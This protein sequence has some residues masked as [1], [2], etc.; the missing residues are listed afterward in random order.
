[1]GGGLEHRLLRHVRLDDL[2]AA[3][4]YR[5]TDRSSVRGVTVG[6]LKRRHARVLRSGIGSDRLVNAVKTEARLTSRL[7]PESVSY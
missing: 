5:R 4:C 2:Q 7:I 1:M 3:L 6:L